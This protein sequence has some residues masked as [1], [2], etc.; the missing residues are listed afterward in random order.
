MI[1]RTEA[2]TRHQSGFKW[3]GVALTHTCIKYL[4]LIEKGCSNKDIASELY[5]TPISTSR[6]LQAIRDQFN[7]SK[8]ELIIAL[9]ND[10]FSENIKKSLNNKRIEDNETTIRT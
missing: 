1:E 3:R 6:R 7:L 2:T 5:I 8:I 4:M 10:S 9:R